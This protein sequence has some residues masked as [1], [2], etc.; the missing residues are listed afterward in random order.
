VPRVP[1][2]ADPNPP[3]IAD[4]IAAVE[5]WYDPSWAEDWD[6]V[7][8]VCGDPRAPVSRIVLAIDVVPATVTAAQ[9]AQLLI[10]HHPLLLTAVHAVPVTDPKG[11]LVHR[12]IR[13]GLA[14]YVAHTNAEV[15]PDGVSDAL[16]ATLGVRAVTPLEAATAPGAVGIGRVGQLDEAVTLAHFAAVVA[17]RLPATVGGARVSGDPGRSVRRVAVLG[18]SGSSMV[19]AARAAGADVLVTADLRHH[20]AVEAVT[21][22]GASPAVVRPGAGSGAPPHGPESIMALIDVAHWASEVPWLHLLARRLRGEFG[23][24]VEVTV[25]DVVTDPWTVHVPSPHSERDEGI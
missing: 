6:A 18:G 25:S 14:H 9:P 12:M 13:T 11:A 15:G 7:G 8:L 1:A 4:V 3:V 24:T 10:T 5:S 22:R 21:Q 23:D 19:D 2:P 17:D 20:N 16:A